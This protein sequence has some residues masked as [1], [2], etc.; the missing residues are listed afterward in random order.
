[1]RISLQSSHFLCFL[2]RA[3]FSVVFCYVVVCL[4]LG[5][6]RVARPVFYLLALGCCAWF[7]IWRAPVAAP[8]KKSV[9]ALEIITF[10]VALTLFLGE[11][12]LRAFAA[13]SHHS[14]I[15]SSALDAYRL[16]PG[17][18]YAGGLRGNQLGFPGPDFCWNKRP[19]VFRIAALGDS[20]AV[21]PTVPF[22]DNFLTRLETTLPS[23]E[24]YNFG[25]SGTGPREYSLILSRDVWTY[26]PDFVLVSVFVGNDITEIMATPRR[27]DLRQLSLYLFVTRSARLLVENWR[28]SED[29]LKANEEPENEN[30]AQS[31]LSLQ[32]FREVEARRL[33]IC[34]QPTPPD[35]EMK[36]QRAESYLD[37][38]VADCR[39][40]KVGV[41]FVSIPDQFQVDPKV[42]DDAL[43]DS[44]LDR[45]AIDIESPQRRLSA[46]FSRRGVACLDLLPAFRHAADA[47][48]PHDT[49]WNIKGNHLAARC[50]GEW[51][52]KVAK[53]TE[54]TEHTET[55][56][57]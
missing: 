29:D 6:T 8:Q 40:H 20:F 9:L 34:S 21:G 49:H 5:G 52:K 17:H 42:L 24:V 13:C 14:L 48:T 18:R 33:A 22:S 43:K 45:E 25:V 53:T 44:H 26:R 2:R 7:W 30:G 4:T 10:N 54:H 3:F 11:L 38:I 56:K 32:T 39:K 41:A 16:T 1:L 36:W 23:T 37:H 55:K 46:F 51:L 31:A 27:M 15:V 28:R 57:K 47:Y 19:G 50:I 12:S 35:L